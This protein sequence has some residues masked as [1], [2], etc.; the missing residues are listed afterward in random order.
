[1]LASPFI[2]TDGIGM[3]QGQ[4]DFIQAFKQASFAKRIDVEANG[5]TVGCSGR[6]GC[7]VD[8]QMIAGVRVFVGDGSGLGVAD[9]EPG[10][11]SGLGVAD[12]EPARQPIFASVSA[13]K[14]SK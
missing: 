3:L 6:L 9:G 2:F 10:A 11:G 1:M 5:L 13:L 7:Q 8:D 14:S 4:S 12:G